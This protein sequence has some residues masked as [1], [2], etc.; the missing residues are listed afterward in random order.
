M[1]DAL[2]RR[3][4]HLYVPYPDEKLE[5][6]ILSTRVPDLPETLRKEIVSFVQDVR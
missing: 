4:L 3:C 2:K 6:Q 1:S 5:S